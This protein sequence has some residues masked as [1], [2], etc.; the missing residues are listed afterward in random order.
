MPAI[1]GI[2]AF[3]HDS[4]AALVVDGEIVAAAQEE[5]FTR[6]KN[7]ERF[8]INA[9]NYCLAESGLNPEQIDYVGF[10]DKPYLK[11]ERILE[12]NLAVAPRGISQFYATL[13][14]WL[15]NK[16][17]VPSQ[18]R[19]ALGGGYKKRLIFAEHHEAHAASAF[20]P[21]P[22]DEAAILTL[23]GVGEW[24]T[25]SIG[26]GI[27]NQITLSHQQNFPH[28]LGLLYAAFTSYSGFK[29]NSGEYKVMGLAPYGEPRFKD[30]ILDK[31]IDLKTDGSFKMD[32]SYF[33][34]CHGLTM[35]STKFHKLFGN[36]PRVPESPL[37]QFHKDIAASIQKVAEEIMI[38]CAIHAHHLTQKSN[39]CMAGGVALNCV[40]NGRILRETPFEKVWVQPA[41][42]DSGGALGVALYIHHQLLGKER[43]ASKKDFQRGS[44]LGPKY[45]SSDCRDALISQNAR[46][47]RIKDDDQRCEWIAD[48]IEKGKVVG[49]L[50]GRMEF[51]PRALGCR[52]ILGDARRPEMQKTINLKIKFR[53][54]FRPFAPSIL[55][56]YSSDYFKLQG[57]IE[58][59]YMLFVD[60]AKTEKLPAVTH[61]DGTSRFQTVD[62][63][64]NPFYYKLLKTFEKKSGCPAI[65]NTSFNIR[66]EPI[67]CSPSDA[68]HCFMNTDMDALAI[69]DYVLTK[70]GQDLDSYSRPDTKK[71]SIISP[72]NLRYFGILLGPFFALFSWVTYANWNNLTL[73]WSIAT[74]GAI[75]T[76]LYL[77]I[78][79]LQPHL[80]RLW[81]AALHPIAWTVSH[82]VMSLFYYLFFTPIGLIMR[83]SGN[84]PLTRKMDSQSKSYWL[85]RNTDIKRDPNL[86]FRQF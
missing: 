59:P 16:L 36:A 65:I 2:S 25:S 41:A 82:L 66:G 33:N 42:S 55:H 31:I 13:P 61:V 8:P 58:S 9:V 51:G 75:F 19:G 53:E 39:L 85:A 28:S 6:L 45:S 44:L 72:R 74:I 73:S 21:S 12:S 4:A 54:S 81:M 50:Q 79:K 20:F 17:H 24:A 48:K 47:T 1:L 3:Y 68:W 30:K 7:D 60:E 32:L 27:G 37:T 64:R 10:Y 52:S 57:N 11:F 35:T 5:R 78:P 46:F 15:A 67:V 70:E 18:I 69:E 86:P 56:E 71:V 14:Q 62:P 23:D 83:M 76:T 26:V 22:F 49:L 43:H 38:R 34:Y 40:G 80:Y 29:V 84:D 77:S 63:E